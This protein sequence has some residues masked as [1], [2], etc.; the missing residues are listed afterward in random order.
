MD[1]AA[2]GTPERVRD[3]DEDDYDLLTFNEAGIRLAE[4]IAEVEAALSAAVGDEGDTA[5]LRT[6][7]HDLREA[8]DR[9]SPRRLDPGAFKDFFGYEPGRRDR[10]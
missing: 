2:H 5:R 10:R 9:N 3:P 4:Q 7:L 6:R 8:R 1:S